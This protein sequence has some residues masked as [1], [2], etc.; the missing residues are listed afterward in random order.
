MFNEKNLIVLEDKQAVNNDQDVNNDQ[1]VTYVQNYLQ[2]PI[3]VDSHHGQIT[4]ANTALQNSKSSA[5]EIVEKLNAMQFPKLQLQSRIP[6]GFTAQSTRYFPNMNLTP[7]IFP[8]T[9]HFQRPHTDE[10]PFINEHQ[11]EKQYLTFCYA[12]LAE[13]SVIMRSSEDI[14]TDVETSDDVIN[15]QNQGH[16]RSPSF[17]H[18]ILGYGDIVPNN[19]FRISSTF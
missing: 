8:L 12:K 19:Y 3:D 4:P 18:F 2:T 11:K 15:G 14:F 17:A 1:A 10:E 16:L 5:L 6:F 7:F 13:F 9:I